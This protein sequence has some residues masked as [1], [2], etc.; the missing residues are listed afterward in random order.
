M[1]NQFSMFCIADKNGW[2]LNYVQGSL[3]WNQPIDFDEIID[4]THFSSRERAE[5]FIMNNL[6]D[7]AYMLHIVEYVL[8]EA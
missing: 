7:I 4:S 1:A 2:L 5:K 3:F 8:G 6:S